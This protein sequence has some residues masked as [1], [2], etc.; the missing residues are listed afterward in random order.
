MRRLG[1]RWDDP[2]VRGGH[3]WLAVTLVIG[4]NAILG[5]EDDVAILCEDG[6]QCPSGF[7]SAEFSCDDTQWVLRFGG[8]GD[9]VA[10][11]V[12][13]IDEDREG[14]ESGMT[15]V[16]GSFEEEISFG[17]DITLRSDG[18]KDGFVLA[19]DP[20]GAVLWA[21]QFAG[22]GSQVVTAIDVGDGGDI[23]V[24][25]TFDGNTRFD[26]IDVEASP[27]VFAG[28]AAKLDRDGEIQ[29]VAPFGATDALTVADVA[30][31]ETG[32]A[33]VGSYTGTALNTEVLP[34]AERESF[35]WVSVTDDGELAAAAGLP[36]TVTSLSCCVVMSDAFSVP[37]LAGDFSG[38]IIDS[39]P[40]RVA[41]GMADGWIT[42]PAYADGGVVGLELIQANSP[43]TAMTLK[44]TRIITG[45][46]VEAEGTVTTPQLAVVRGEYPDW[47]DGQIVRAD[48]PNENGS[49]VDVFT[50][51]D[52]QTFAFGQFS[53]ELRFLDGPS[54]D[55]RHQSVFVAVMDPEFLLP[56]GRTRAFSGEG[57]V[58]AGG[59]SIEPS[60]NVILAGGFEEQLAL[61]NDFGAPTLESAGG[62]DIYVANLRL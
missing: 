22:A 27:D 17:E 14:P 9:D 3:P 62:S 36:T 60:G 19:L 35:A 12:L 21:R 18:G 49:I 37:V 55:V 54:F 56:T 11:D 47:D 44:G 16:V 39:D 61:E 8:E 2:P 58:S 32:V 1:R 53:D 31:V 23:Y 25:G 30:Y 38:T 57:D 48:N 46:R 10:H 24:A 40:P 43:V 7:C 28:F 52:D 13:H 41:S 50:T 45:H 33:V 20:A 6:S 59:M 26:E 34:F 29:W 4:C 51:D 5:I 15:V 42:E